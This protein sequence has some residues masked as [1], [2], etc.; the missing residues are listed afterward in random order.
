[1]TLSFEEVTGWV[2][3]PLDA[4]GIADYSLWWIDVP[5]V[6]RNPHELY[7]R[8]WRANARDA[9]P[10]PEVEPHLARIFEQ[11]GTEAGVIL[12]HRRLLWQAHLPI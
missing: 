4:A 2:T 12:R 3:K 6:L 8:L 11:H 1:M 10:Y 9:P 7:M 5:E